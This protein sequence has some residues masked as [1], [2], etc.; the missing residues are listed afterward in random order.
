MVDDDS[1]PFLSPVSLL[2][3]CGL[4]TIPSGCFLNHVWLHVMLN[5]CVTCFCAGVEVG[6]HQLLWFA[7]AASSSA[8]MYSSSSQ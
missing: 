4:C 6:N 8:T 3:N 5:S 2:L 7:F 1:K